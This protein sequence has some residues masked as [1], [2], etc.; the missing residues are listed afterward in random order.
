VEE[1]SVSRTPSPPEDFKLE[2]VGLGLR[3]KPEEQKRTLVEQSLAESVYEKEDQ[4]SYDFTNPTEVSKE[5]E[6]V[7]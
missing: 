5:E 1:S 6:K 2:S 3:G 7:L 4:S